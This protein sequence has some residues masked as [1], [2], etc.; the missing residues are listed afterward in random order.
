[1]SWP[2]LNEEACM[3]APTTYRAN[4]SSQHSVSESLVDCIVQFR[5]MMQDPMKIVFLRP[6]IL[7]FTY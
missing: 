3:A 1:M 7:P 6:N 4:Y 5:T 2:R